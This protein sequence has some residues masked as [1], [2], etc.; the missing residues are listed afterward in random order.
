MNAPTR[1]YHCILLIQDSTELDADAT[2][3]ESLA[4]PQPPV[5][6]QKLEVPRPPSMLRLLYASS[7]T[8]LT[9]QAGDATEASPLVTAHARASAARMKVL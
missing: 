2:Q 5:A 9:S 6:A 4:A 3:P 8:W 7:G 1:R